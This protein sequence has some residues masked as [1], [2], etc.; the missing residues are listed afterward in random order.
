MAVALKLALVDTELF[1]MI[2]SNSKMNNTTCPTTDATERHHRGASEPSSVS[3][4][5]ASRV[6]CSWVHSSSTSSPSE[7]LGEAEA[8][9]A[10][11]RLNVVLAWGLV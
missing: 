9:E 3:N 7:G 4:S 6:A 11:V 10:A 2:Q 5:G 8:A 1:Q